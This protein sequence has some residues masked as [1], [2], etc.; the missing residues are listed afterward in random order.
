MTLRKTI[1]AISASHR[2][3]NCD[4]GY[5]QRNAYNIVKNE[6]IIVYYWHGRG[7]TSLKMIKHDFLKIWEKLQIWEA[8]KA[9]IFNAKFFYK[10][11]FIFDPL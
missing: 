4:W 8:L 9:K 7:Q 11:G 5:L 3:D 2:Q 10:K 1:F 6:N